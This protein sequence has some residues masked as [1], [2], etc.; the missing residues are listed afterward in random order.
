MSFVIILDILR[1]QEYYVDYLSG[2][3]PK[4]FDHP[5]KGGI[6]SVPKKHGIQTVLVIEDE[7]DIQNFICR[8]LEFEGYHV[9]K[10]ANGKTGLDIIRNDSVNLVLLDLRMPGTDGWSVLREIKSNP[11]LS[12]TPVVVLTAIAE[13]SQRRRTLRMGA[14]RYL[15]KPLSAHGLSKAIAKI[16]HKKGKEFQII[17]ADTVKSSLTNSED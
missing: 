17:S 13:S 9:L 1:I 2:R 11:E 16:L 8:V 3:L 15:I 12:N 6:E 5:G 4:A 10:A 7:I 14:A